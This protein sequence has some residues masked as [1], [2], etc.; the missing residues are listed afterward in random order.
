M[1]EGWWRGERNSERERKEFE[2]DKEGLL[3]KCRGRELASG[4]KRVL[5]WIGKDYDENVE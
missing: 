5:K 2:R 4:K 1:R 3:G